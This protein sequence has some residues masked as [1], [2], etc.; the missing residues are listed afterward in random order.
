MITITSCC[1]NDFSHYHEVQDSGDYY[2]FRY[3]ISIPGIPL[4]NTGGLQMQYIITAI[5][6]DV[7]NQL[8]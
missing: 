8:H 5:N 6:K 4:S 3:N 2:G 1:K 7:D